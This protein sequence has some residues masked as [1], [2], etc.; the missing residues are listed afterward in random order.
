MSRAAD[1]ASVGAGIASSANATAIS[2]SAT[3]VVTLLTSALATSEG[4]AATTIIAQGLAKAWTFCTDNVITDSLNTSSS[5]DE[6]TGSYIVT[7]SNNTATA[8]VAGNISCNENT[9]L[10]GHR[11]SNSTSTYQIRLKDTSGNG[12]DANS[13]ATVHGDLA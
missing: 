8:N 12:G 2:I 4:G 1:L 11:S 7:L 9:N 5:S 10:I 3:E 6:A 13:G